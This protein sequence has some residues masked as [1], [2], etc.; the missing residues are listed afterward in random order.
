[1]GGTVVLLVRLA[2]SMAV[3]MCV[4]A[5]AARLV[6]RRQG[7]GGGRAMGGAYV[8]AGGGAYGKAAGGR[9]ANRARRAR[10]DVPVEIVYRRSLA[11][12]ANLTL[13][14]AGGK[15]YLLGV[16]EQAVNVLA[17]VTAPAPPE[18]AA[19][20]VLGTNGTGAY[21][22]PVVDLALATED[23]RQGTGWTPGP[24]A[25][26]T[27]QGQPATAWKLAIESLRERTVRR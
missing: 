2:I 7:A 23:L 16:T 21:R 22:A 9:S 24:L 27:A 18:G 17:E 13:V 3:V 8:K 6:R 14:E 15:R 20:E 25:G 19:A 4:M 12:G 10:P 11:K 5:V 26:A 1:M